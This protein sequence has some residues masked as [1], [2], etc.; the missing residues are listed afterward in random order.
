VKRAVLVSLVVLASCEGRDRHEVKREVDRQ[1]RVIESPSGKVRPLPPHAIRADGVGPYRLRASLAE[2]LEQLPSGPRM[3]TL[4]I[5]GVVHRSLLR[6]EDDAI[7]IGGEPFGKASFI[8][9]IGDQIA[10]T[11]SGVHVG[12]TRDELVRALGAPSDDV[13]QARDPRVIVPG[14]LRNARVVLDGERIVALVVVAA[15]APAP[16]NDVRPAAKDAG[17][18]D[19]GCV[20]P[21]PDPDHAK[22]IP[23]CLAGG[24]YIAID[25]D[26]IVVRPRTSESNS[27]PERA[28]APPI[29]VSGL[30]FAAPLRTLEGRDELVAIARADDVQ[31]RTWTLSVFRLD[32]GRLVRTLEQAP[33]YQLTAANARWM[34]AELRDLDLYIEL[35]SHT[36][37]IEVGGLLTTRI[38]DKLRDVVVISPVVVPRHRAKSAPPE[39]ADAGLSD[40]AGDTEARP[41]DR[42]PEH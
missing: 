26:E 14:T 24:D 42:Q 8:A 7:L 16:T 28:L 10:R 40:A 35:S 39:A 18:P 21:P 9:V 37:A 23:S 25:G 12:S 5:P 3:A 15:A 31:Q 38:N 20:R 34:G 27:A 6:A 11:E 29:R 13:D 30:V 33:L 17:V 36:D 19:T 22:R 32:A 2:L 4:D 1:P 41:A